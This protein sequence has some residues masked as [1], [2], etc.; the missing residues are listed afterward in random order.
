MNG[1][2]Y[3]ISVDPEVAVNYTGRS[4]ALLSVSYDTKYN[5]SVVASLCGITMTYFAI[6]NHGK[7]GTPS[8]VKFSHPLILIHTVT[9]PPLDSDNPLSS[10]RIPALVGSVATFSC[11]PGKILSGSNLTT[12]T[13]NRQWHP[14][15]KS[16]VVCKGKSSIL[17]LKIHQSIS[18]IVD[19]TVPTVKNISL[20]YNSTLED[21]LLTFQCDDGLFPSD[22]FTARCYRNGS[23]I[24]SPS[25][26]ICTTLSAGTSL[27]IIQLTYYYFLQNNF[28]A[29][30]LIMI[31]FHLTVTVGANY[32]LVSL[33]S[34]LGVLV[35]LTVI[36]VIIIIA[37][38]TKKKGQSC[39]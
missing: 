33:S 26:H 4:S 32:L 9:C 29:A 14:D 18:I 24:P 36:I 1:V 35:V 37:S 5:V 19:C 39:L 3:S 31:F 30:R 8:L 21:S 17:N 12:C 23:W 22:I 25:G 38:I 34:S 28:V 2:S 10:E 6:I 16:N 13:A 7:L 15:P 27:Y 11:P 20:N